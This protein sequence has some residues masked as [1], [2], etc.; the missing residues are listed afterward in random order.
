MAGTSMTD[1]RSAEIAANLAEVRGRIA[2]ACASAGRNPAEVTLVAV[3]KTFGADDVRRLL[4]LGLADVAENRD[5][6]ARAKVAALAADPPP[7]PARWHFV[8]RLQRNK[9]RSVAGYASAVHSVDRN[10]LVDALA[11]GAG[12][13]DRP[14]L[15]VLIQVSLDADTARGGALP[16]DVPALAAAVVAAAPL[17]LRGVM[18][19]APQDADPDAA[20]DRLAAV[21]AT[22]RADHPEATAIS[23]GMSGDLEAAIRHGATHVRVGTALLGGR[24]P[25]VG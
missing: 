23:A 2:A 19:V 4:A 12:R 5:Q 17:R 13:A 10:E 22:L 18:A 11:A 16:A 25:A 20:F 1:P 8:G 6:E 9:C 7:A 3:T 14:A 15:D 21:A 24:A